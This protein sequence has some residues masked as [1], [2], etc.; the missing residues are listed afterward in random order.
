[1]IDRANRPGGTSS[2][3]IRWRS[4]VWLRSLD[5]GIWFGLAIAVVLSLIVIVTAYLVKVHWTNDAS[6]TN[7]PDAS[8]LIAT[9]IA[10]YSLFITSFSVLAGFVAVRKIHNAPKIAAIALLIAA[11]AWDLIQLLN[12]TGDLY[13]AATTGLTFRQLRDDVHDFQIYFF[14]SVG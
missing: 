5:A 14:I 3:V 1:D 12:S 13:G 4:L 10:L 8:V 6:T 2:P 11:T 9:F 7:A